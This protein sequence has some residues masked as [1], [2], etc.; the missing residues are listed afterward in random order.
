MNKKVFTPVSEGQIIPIGGFNWKVKS[1]TE[2][3]MILEVCGVSKSGKRRGYVI[4]LKDTNEL[5]EENKV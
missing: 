4:N 3:T 2:T 5:D 1:C